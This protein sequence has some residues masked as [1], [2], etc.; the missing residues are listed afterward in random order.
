MVEARPQT[1]RLTFPEKLA[2]SAEFVAVH[3]TLGPVSNSCQSIHCFAVNIPTH[4][5]HPPF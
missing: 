1:A 3:R 2:S 5:F 4:L